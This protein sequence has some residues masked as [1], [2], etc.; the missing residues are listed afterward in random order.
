MSDLTVPFVGGLIVGLLKGADRTFRNQ[1][2][3]TYIA[4]MSH[5]AAQENR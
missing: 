2:F 1:R 4:V 5:G 3:M